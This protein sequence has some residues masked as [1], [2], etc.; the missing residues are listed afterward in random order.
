[1]FHV[2]GEETLVADLMEPLVFPVIN[3]LVIFFNRVPKGKYRLSKKF[4]V[5]GTQPPI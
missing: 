3:A 1:M 2:Q 4:L 5:L